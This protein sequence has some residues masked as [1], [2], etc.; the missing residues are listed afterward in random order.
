MIDEM[1]KDCG[2]EAVVLG[3][4]DNAGLIPGVDYEIGVYLNEQGF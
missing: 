1:A 4:T 2:S 3:R